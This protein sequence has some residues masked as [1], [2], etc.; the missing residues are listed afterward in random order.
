[1]QRHT[2]LL[3]PG[4]SVLAATSTCLATN[5]HCQSLDSILNAADKSELDL[6]ATRSAQKS[7]NRSS[8]RNQRS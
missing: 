5:A 1:M 3:M 6:S 7:E 8:P 2:P 4:V